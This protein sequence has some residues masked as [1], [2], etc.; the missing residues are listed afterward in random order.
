M[1]LVKR[2]SEPV[3]LMSI[4]YLNTRME[5]TEK[6][7]LQYSNLEKGYEGEVKFDRLAEILQEE[8]LIINDLLLEVNNSYFQ[9]DTLIISE[10]MI[11]LLE[12]KN[13][14]GDWYLESDKLYTVT[15][16]REYKNPV[17]QLKRSAALLR[18]LLQTLKQNYPVEASVVFINP[19]FTL[20][21]A[22]MDQPIVLPTQVNRFIKDLNKTPSNLNDGHTKLAQH[23]MSLHQPK[24]PFTVWPKYH[25]EQLKKGIHCKTCKSLPL[26]IKSKDLV[27]KKCG[28]NEKI[29][30]A[31]LRN[32]K[33]FQLLFPER[34]LTTQNIYEWCNLDL[35]KRTICRVL[36]KNYT[37][38]GSTSNTYYV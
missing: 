32:I 4:R 2:R 37:A 12:I 10:S 26:T 7:K 36:K 14:Q 28:G 30:Q 21:Q 19:E 11:H 31:I 13:F 29:E 27:C 24:N 20:Y 33:E 18:Q 23:L 8:R 16:G 34:K 3:E 17:Y 1:M 25:F 38:L 6:E 22:P 5:L 9:I 15:A 35:S